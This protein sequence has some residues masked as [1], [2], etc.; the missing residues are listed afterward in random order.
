MESVIIRNLHQ[1]ANNSMLVG[2]MNIEQLKN[3][4]KFTYRTPNPHDPF[5]DNFKEKSKETS[6]YYQRIKNSD[7]A[8]QIKLFFLKHIWNK[9]YFEESRISPL[10]VFPSSIILSLSINSDE[11][12]TL[13]DYQEYIEVEKEKAEYSF[14]HNNELQIPSNEQSLIID[15]QHRIA[16]LELLYEDA[17]KREIKLNKANKSDYYVN[18]KKEVPFEYILDEIKKFQFIVTFL[19]NFDPYEQA[20]IFATVNFNQTKVNKSFYYDIFGSSSSK[21][22]EKLLHDI[23]SHLNYKTD[24]PLKNKIKMLGTGPG[25]FSQS[26]FVD[27]L[28]P[29]F[30]NGVFSFLYNDFQNNGEVYKKSPYLFK[31]YFNT[32]LNHIF[33]KFLP[34]KNSSAILLK[35]T[36]MGALIKLM[37]NVINEIKRINKIS[38]PKDLLDLNETKLKEDIENIFKKIKNNG[39]KYFGENSGFAKGA[40]KGLQ[41]RLYGVI[42]ED[43]GFKKQNDM[44]EAT[45]V[46]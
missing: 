45:P 27:A 20:E 29:H 24:S 18:P 12:K 14:I 46:L 28:I 2:E 40:G 44:E 39:E 6:L 41:G 23:T 33:D 7:R 4:R 37:P 8:Y 11:L 25:Y 9:Y 35:T 43:L 21:A 19:V 17:I 32:L 3:I 1:L 10:G 36:G 38:N 26:F 13:K 30:K 34:E 15:G 42:F 22:V 16:G 31:V 5:E